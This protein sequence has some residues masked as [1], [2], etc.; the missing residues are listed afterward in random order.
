MRV[1]RHC[2]RSFIY[3]IFGRCSTPAA[4]R[5][6]CVTAQATQMSD[7]ALEIGLKRL[8]LKQEFKRE[9]N[10]QA[11]FGLRCTALQLASGC[12]NFA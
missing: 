1:A 10:V 4:G 7:T 12:S 9:F 3:S 11:S 5:A 2:P 8:G 6:H